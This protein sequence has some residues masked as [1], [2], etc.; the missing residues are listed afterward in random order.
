MNEERARERFEKALA[1]YRQEFETFFL[2]RL[3]DLG[4]EYEEELCRIKFPV[5]E[6]LFN[7]QGSLHGGAI[8]TVM[9]I[10]MGHLLK[11]ATGTPGTTLEMKVQYMR[12]LTSGTA[13]CEGR[14]LRRGRSLSFMESRMFDDDG[15]LAAMATATWKMPT[16]R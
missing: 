3:L 7:P 15:K 1:T 4:F 6:F 12:P 8:A 13:C 9:D 2:A 14:I 10:S 5:E 11:H 16:P